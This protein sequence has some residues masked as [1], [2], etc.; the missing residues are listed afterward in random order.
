M[1]LKPFVKW[2]GGKRQL[3]KHLVPLVPAEYNVYHEPFLGGGAML[4]ELQPKKAIVNDSNKELMNCYKV[5]KYNCDELC[6]KIKEYEA[7]KNT[8]DTFEFLRNSFNQK[9]KT[10]S[11]D[12]EMACF[13]LILNQ[14]CFNGLYRVNSKNEFNSSWGKG[15]CTETHVDVDNLRNI[16]DFLNKNDIRMFSTDFVNVSKLVHKDDFVFF[17]SPYVPLSETANFDRYTKEKFKENDHKTLANIYKML[18][19]KGVKEILTN[20]NTSLVR[21]LYAG[22]N[23]TEV[24]AQRSINCDGKKRIGKEIIITNFETTKNF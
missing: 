4:F 1:K 15:V 10:D 8:R 24:V 19:N 5:I 9:I 17:D 16:S 3:L 21:E 23:I 11:Y 14:R 12:A 22:Y 2:A 20:H 13:F 18:D 6:Q 7:L